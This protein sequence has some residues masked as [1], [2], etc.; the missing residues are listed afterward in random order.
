MTRFSL[1]IPTYDRR[2]YLRACLDSVFAQQQAPDEIIVVD[3]GSRDG[4]IEMLQAE[5]RVTLVRQ[6]NRGP[7]AARNRGA[8]E[9]GGDY[10]V[11]LDSDDLWFP[12]SLASMAALIARHGE[13]AL[14][15]ARF[16]D[17]SGDRPERVRE[18]PAEG[19]AFPDYLASAAEGCFA[20]AGMMVIRRAA[21]E[22][23]G[24]FREARV[25]A[26][27]H[28]LALRLGTEAGF[29]QVRAPVTLAHRVH[30]GNEMGDAARNL[31]GL[32]RL[33]ATERAGGYP[34]GAARRAA[35]RTIIAR[36]V[37]AAVLGAARGG[38]F[39]QVADLYRDTFLWNLRAGRVAYLAA[40]PLLALRAR[41]T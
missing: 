28:D 17:F 19:S 6:A 4:T 10:L 37:R 38:Q 7:G 20:G 3:D 40:T 23:V 21:F 5:P 35:R 32:R 8:A 18:A 24:G 41:K 11:F 25:N 34:G 30:D 2:D 26:E 1:V 29:V 22:A 15:F 12:W 31:A 9:A 39:G 14:L 33:V 13:P 16:A 27:D 36:H